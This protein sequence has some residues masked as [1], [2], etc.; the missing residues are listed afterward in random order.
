MSWVARITVLSCLSFLAIPTVPAQEGRDPNAPAPQKLAY[1][2][3]WS[4][5]GVLRRAI[6][7]KDGQPTYVLE[8]AKGRVLIYATCLPGMTLR[9]YVGRT[10]ALYGSLAMIAVR[11]AVSPSIAP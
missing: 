4:Q 9:D 8:D 5:V 1:P 7:D 6:A 3:Q 10:V 2:P 11:A